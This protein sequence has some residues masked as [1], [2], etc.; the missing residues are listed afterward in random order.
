MSVYLCSWIQ[1][2]RLRAPCVDLKQKERNKFLKKKYTFCAHKFYRHETQLILLC[3]CWISK[4]LLLVLVFFLVD[5]Y[6]HCYCLRWWDDSMRNAEKTRMDLVNFIAKVYCFQF[7][8][9]FYCFK[10]K[11]DNFFIS[12][13]FVIS[14]SS[15]SWL[16]SKPNQ[17]NDHHQFIAMQ[18]R[19]S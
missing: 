7:Q 13:N 6:T 2:N 12:L 4:L 16:R 3:W 9:E 14:A 19:Y 17:T 1:S 11:F 8:I 15:R 5:G 18:K 10:Q